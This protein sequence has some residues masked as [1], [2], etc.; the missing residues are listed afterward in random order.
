MITHKFREVMAF[1]DEVTILRRGRLAGSRSGRRAHAGRHGRHDDRRAGTDPA[2]PRASA[3]SARRG[4]SS[5]MLS[6]LD[7]AGQPALHDVTLAIQA[8]EIVGIAGR[9]GQRP[10]RSWS[11]C[12][13]GSARLQAGR[14]A[15]TASAIMPTREE[16]RRHKLVLPAGG[17]AEERLR[18]AHERRRESGVSRFRPRAL[19]RRR[20]VA[21]AKANSARRPS[22]RS[23]ATRSRPA[24]PIRRSASCPAATCSAPCWRGSSAAR[25]RC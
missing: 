21:A 16:M 7:D 8:G 20:L 14:S 12:W 15:S 19:R 24:R 13:P 2:P 5:T 18:R 17:A 10:A 6:A 1:A 11:R 3:S 9:V 22:A 25:S 23:R 4:S